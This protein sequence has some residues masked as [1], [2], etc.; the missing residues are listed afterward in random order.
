MAL[1]CTPR[2]I[3]GIY[4]HGHRDVH[5][6]PQTPYSPSSRDW[7][8]HKLGSIFLGAGDNHSVASADNYL[9]LLG[10]GDKTIRAHREVL[11]THVGKYIDDLVMSARGLTIQMGD[12]FY[13]G[14][15]INGESLPLS[16][17]IE[18][19]RDDFIDDLKRGALH[20]LPALP[21]ISGSD[22]SSARP[23]F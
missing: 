16:P 3:A 8:R 17:K 11:K 13:L 12:E 14:V 10:M 5:E 2:I 21:R 9:R 15:R 20:R 18:A 7:A 23:I 19:V 22:G 1:K 4:F 6:R